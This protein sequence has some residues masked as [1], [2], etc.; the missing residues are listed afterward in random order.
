MSDNRQPSPG[1]SPHW[2]IRRADQAVVATLVVAGLVSTVGW[3]ISQGGVNGRLIELEEAEPR[4]AAF[5][6]DV[7]GAAWPEL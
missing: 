7:N 3:W 1:P 6:V 5:E 2:L 4:V